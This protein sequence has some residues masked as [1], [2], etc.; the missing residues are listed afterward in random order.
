MSRIVVDTNCLIQCISSRSIY[1][2]IWLS[3]LDGRNE[4]CVTNEI[5]EEY[6]EII[7]RNVSPRFASLAVD[8]II[9]NPY[10]K[11]ITPFYEFHLIT[12][13]PDDNKFV[14]C[15]VAANARFLVSEDHHLNVL[16]ETDFPKVNLIGLDDFL[17]ELEEETHN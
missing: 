1:H 4:L 10:T 14:D 8:V 5:I 16:K 3:L 2:E 7:G 13:D 11:F 17:S 12:E 9:N 15:A 6:E